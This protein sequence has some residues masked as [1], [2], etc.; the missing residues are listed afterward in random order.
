MNRYSNICKWTVGLFISVSLCA[1]G[2][3]QEAVNFGKSEHSPNSSESSPDAS[4]SSPGASESEP[5]PIVDPEVEANTKLCQI[6]FTRGGSHSVTIGK[7]QCE[8]LCQD[9][10]DKNPSKGLNC[11]WGGTVFF[12]VLSGKQCLIQFSNGASHQVTFS[13]GECIQL[14]G[15][16]KRNNPKST[17]TCTW[18]GLEV[19]RN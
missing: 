12:E 1:C 15:T 7:A 19:G 6:A 10:Q 14:C 3:Q 2:G 8:N 11:S 16:Y 9:Y 17:F 5:T 4:E 18:D 13:Q